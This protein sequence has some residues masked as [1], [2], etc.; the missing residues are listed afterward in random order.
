V[1]NQRLRRCAAHE[2]GLA[3]LSRVFR[4]STIQTF[5]FFF[6]CVKKCWAEGIFPFEKK[7][8]GKS[9]RGG[10]GETGGGEMNGKKRGREGRR[11]REPKDDE[12]DLSFTMLKIKNLLKPFRVKQVILGFFLIPL[13]PLISRSFPIFFNLFPS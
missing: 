9:E 3:P 6:S 4:N 11:E 5:V 10:R 1:A 12:N 2:R 13:N 7:K 8:R